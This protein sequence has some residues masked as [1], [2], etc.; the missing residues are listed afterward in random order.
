MHSRILRF[1]GLTMAALVV[2]CGGDTTTA[3]PSEVGPPASVSVAAGDNQIAAPGA[4]VATAPSVMVRD[5]A[6]HPVPGVAVAFSVDSGGGSL[7]SPSATTNASGIASAGTWTLG[8]AEGPQVLGV[9]AGSLAKVKI[10]GVA[11][12]ATTTLATGTVS[13]SG[14]TITVN[15]PGSP[16]NG[17]SLT[18]QSTS[19]VSA[20]PIS[21]GSGSNAGI[22]L[23]PG[24][25]ATSPALMIS[26]A[27]TLTKP[28]VVRFPIT[29]IPG[30][31]QFI[32]VFDPATGKV[33]ILTPISAKANELTAVLPRFNSSLLAPP[34]GAVTGRF[35]S[36][37]AK[38]E[39]EIGIL[40][41]GVPLAL[42]D[43]DFTSEFTAGVDNWDFDNLAIAWLPFLAKDDNANPA[44][45]VIDPGHG[46]ITTSL[47]YFLTQ[48]ASGA[49]NKRFRL[50]PDQL[51]S[52]RSGIRWAALANRAAVDQSVRLSKTVDD[53]LT[54]DFGTYTETQFLGLKAMMYFTQRAQPFAEPIPV[55]LYNDSPVSSEELKPGE[56]RKKIYSVAIA[57]ATKTVGRSV[58]FVVAD[59][60]V[61][62]Y[63]G[64]MGASGFTPV[65]VNNRSGYTFT[66][67]SF[68]P[69]MTTPFI[70]NPAISSNYPK[71]LN[72]TVGEAEGWPQPELHWKKG[73]LDTAS[74]I[75]GDEVEMWWECPR[76]TDF[77]TT[78]PGIPPE[79]SH[80]QAFQMGRINGGTSALS[81]PEGL[82]FA[83][84]KW[85][86]DSVASDVNPTKTGHALLL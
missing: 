24:V 15:Q 61:S 52:N 3:P 22:D 59:N 69:Q 73:K 4:A 8:A 45:E 48:R 85:K 19:V 26:S 21:I 38:A 12:A 54:D 39:G 55:Y 25:T 62:T 78:F 70:D 5:A 56:E 46:M 50:Q 35:A 43:R 65:N 40:T 77:G 68:S 76:C 66:F 53:L 33:A 10:R 60:E 63:R 36:L 2:A 28:A 81:P 14:S 31:A 86:A 49:L 29:P 67:S 57:I 18:I 13:T 6:G 1:P 84:I 83:T 30:T 47:W 20:A 72:G 42:L 44:T 79:A 82:A 64:V 23:P 27:A 16:L 58:Y 41:M 75:L 11:R 17:V 80:L 51:R 32:G 37:S 7:S 71:V 34:S 9:V 74:V